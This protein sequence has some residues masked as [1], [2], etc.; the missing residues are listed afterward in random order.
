MLQMSTD[1]RDDEDK[2]KKEEIRKVLR[3]ELLCD[4]RWCIALHCIAFEITI[5]FLLYT[6]ISH[7]DPCKSWSGPR[8]PATARS[9]PRSCRDLS[10]AG[11]L[12]LPRRGIHQS[13]CWFVRA[14]SVN[15]ST[16]DLPLVAAH[17]VTLYPFAMLFFLPQ[18]EGWLPSWLLLVP[19]PF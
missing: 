12:R 19:L 8:V 1:P 4:Q 10:W 17:R 13:I 6:K 11:R 14:A 18:G 7:S 3:S 15:I 16:F 5:E 2:Y 9:E